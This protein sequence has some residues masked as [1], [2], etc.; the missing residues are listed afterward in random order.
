MAKSVK[1]NFAL[2]LINSGTKI[3]FPLI[4]FPYAARILG[5]SGI[6]VVN[7]YNSIISYLALFTGLGIPLYAI[8]EISSVRD[9]PKKVN[10]TL[11][12]IFFISGILTF[13]G[14]IIVA[15]LCI[16]VPQIQANATLFLVLSLILLLNAIGCDWFY[17]GTEDFKYITIRGIIVKILGLI[18]LFLFVKNKTDLIAFGVYSVISAVGGNVFNFIRLRKYATINKTIF[19]DLHPLHHIRPILKIFVLNLVSSIYLQLNTI[20]LGFYKGSEA[21]GYYTSST[22][23]MTVI[24]TFS[25]SLGQVIMPRLSNLLAL[26]KKN[27]FKVLAQKSYNFT[28]AVTFPLS[29]GLLMTSKHAVIL[30]CGNDFYNSIIPAMIVSP[31]IVFSSL[32]NVMGTQILFPL[33]KVNEVIKSAAL[34]CLVDIIL[35][36]ILLNKFSY[37]GAAISYCAAEFTVMFS[38]YFNS[39]KVI[40][41]NFY[42]KDVLIYFVGTLFMGLILF[43]IRNI[44]SDIFVE[45][46]IMFVVGILLYSLILLLF[47]DSLSLQFVGKLNRRI[48]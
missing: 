23:I 37:I 20:M 13:F 43:F 31:I 39:H 10:L 45:F 30:F 17:Q 25:S 38:M 40:P 5:P 33:G 35:N 18:F 47:H 34:G 4:T 32:S 26:N 14:Y 9:D 36:L 8:K 28:V 46:I 15:V 16:F 22:K 44:S 48:K 2:N 24:L 41:V 6:G 1:V 3:L 11:L 19:Y 12:E 42:N 29:M 21:V 27:E 7:F